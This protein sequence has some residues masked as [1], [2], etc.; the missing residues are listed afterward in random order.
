MDHRPSLAFGLTA[1]ARSWNGEL[2]AAIQALGFDELWANDT[3]AGSGLD[4]LADAAAATDHLRLAVG[5]L[6]LSEHTPASI[7]DRVGRLGL[8]LDRLTLGV[9]SGRHRSLAAVR[10]G[11]RELRELEPGV[12]IGIAAVGPR[13]AALAAEVADV[14]LLN[15]M[16]PRLAA[17]RRRAIQAAA[18][19]AGRPAPRVAAYVRVIIGP[20]SAERLAGEQSRYRGFGGSYATV[21]REQMDAGEHLVGVALAEPGGVAAALADYGE[22]LDTVVVRALPAHDTIDEW[23]AVAR[24]ATL[25]G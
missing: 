3:A 5:V 13:M 23:L 10:E 6:G 8:P 20:G 2:A 21:L 22:A 9:G 4:T 7:S 12:V 11:V 24:A 15:W 14:V 25:P 17:D 16:G 18:A 1:A 19:A